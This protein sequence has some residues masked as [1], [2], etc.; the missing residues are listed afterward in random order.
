[1]ETI[2]CELCGKTLTAANNHY[3]DDGGYYVC[4]DCWESMFVDCERCDAHILIDDAYRG[5]DGYL[6]ECCHDD[7]FG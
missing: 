5:N 2:K 3:Y 1:M 7:L 4:D 6:C